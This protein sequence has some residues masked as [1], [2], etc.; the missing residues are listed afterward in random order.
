[1]VVNS[2]ILVAG[3]SGFI[4]SNLINKLLTDSN[5]PVEKGGWMRA[6]VLQSTNAPFVPV[7]SAEEAADIGP[8]PIEVDEGGRAYYLETVGFDKRLI[9]KDTNFTILYTGEYSSGTVEELI[10]EAKIAL[11]LL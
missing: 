1:M 4:G 9:V 11:G 10:E 7:L 8:L 3:G 6:D 5:I 2:K